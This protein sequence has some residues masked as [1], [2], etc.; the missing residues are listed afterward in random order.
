[1]DGSVV[2][3]L[4]AELPNNLPYRL[5]FDNLFTSLKLIDALTERG[6]GALSE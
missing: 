4:I 1:M 2:I 6:I 3:D 5:Y